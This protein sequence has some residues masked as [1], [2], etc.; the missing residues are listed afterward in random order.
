MAAASARER[1]EIR[2][3]K[4][5]ALSESGQANGLCLQRDQSE[6]TLDSD[7]LEHIDQGVRD[8]LGHLHLLL[9]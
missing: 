7:L 1:R 9:S 8:C 6:D 4:F 2:I 3:G 5:D